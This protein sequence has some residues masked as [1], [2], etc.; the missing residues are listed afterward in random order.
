MFILMKIEI[1]VELREV[2]SIKK[3]SYVAAMRNIST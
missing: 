3:L 2:K 1:E